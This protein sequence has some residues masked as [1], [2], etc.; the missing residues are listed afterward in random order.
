MKKETKVCSKC[1]IPKELKEFCKN[2]RYKD[3]RHD[4]CKL[5]RKIYNEQNKK[6]HKKIW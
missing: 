6:K 1:K 4:T 3:K 5:C 2:N